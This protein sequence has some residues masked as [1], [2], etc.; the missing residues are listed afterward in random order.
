MSKNNSA[1]EH[2]E[3]EKIALQAFEIAFDGQGNIKDISDKDK[4][5]SI[6]LF[7]HSLSMGANKYWPYIKLADLV[8]DTKTKIKLY[9]QAWVIEKNHY[10][11]YYLLDTILTDR[12]DTLDRY[13]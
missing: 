5:K 11:A 8:P 1:N 7:N 3:W 10:S 4:Q 6:D 12:P 2:N 13:I 9:L